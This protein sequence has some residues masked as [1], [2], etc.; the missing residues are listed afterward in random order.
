MIGMWGYEP[1]FEDELMARL[2]WAVLA[3]CLYALS[4]AVIGWL[5]YLTGHPLLFPSLGPTAYLL[6]GSPTGSQS[7]PRNTIAGHLLGVAAGGVS[8]AIFGL[9]GAA[10]VLEA[11]MTGAHLGSAALSL[12]LAGAASILLEV[13]HP[14]SGATVLI[15]SLG[16][17]DTPL[18]MA[19]LMAGVVLLTV[20]AWL[21]NRALG[22]RVPLLSPREETP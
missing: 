17:L 22:Y 15:V 1:A 5:A 14:P 8:L 21:A 18:E 3:F 10:S 20:L 2:R 11:G 13:P 4:I 16:F 6:F 7:S 12:A 9:V 19:D